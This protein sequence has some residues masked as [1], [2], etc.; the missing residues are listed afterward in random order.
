[1]PRTSVESFPVGRA[2]I[3]IPALGTLIG[4]Y[5]ADWN[6]THIFNPAW[7]PHAKFHNA[8]TMSMGVALGL[9]SLFYLWRPERSHATLAVGA[10][11]A[12]LYGIT[13]L[14]A[15]LYPGTASADPPREDSWLQLWFTLP[16]LAAVL[17]GYL[18]ERRRLAAAGPAP[19]IR[20]RN[21]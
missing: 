18:L 1:M 20:E 5:V 3:S 7:P 17:I 12:A 11:T 19:A 16:S 15:G 10:V 8:Q 21:G 4:S 6:A 9:V 14:S 2:L 13:Q